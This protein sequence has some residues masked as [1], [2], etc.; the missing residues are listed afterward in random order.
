MNLGIWDLL[1]LF[2]WYMIVL[3]HDQNN[4]SNYIISLSFHLFPM[5]AIMSVSS[6]FASCSITIFN[7]TPK[8]PGGRHKRVEGGELLLAWFSIP[9]PSPSFPPRQLSFFLFFLNSFH[10]LG[11]SV[12]FHLN[13]RF[14]TNCEVNWVHSLLGKAQTTSGHSWRRY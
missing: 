7:C 3:T 4:A 11:L 14:P 6:I 9:D 13:Y 10:V 5:S 8:S 2:T 1:I 12:K